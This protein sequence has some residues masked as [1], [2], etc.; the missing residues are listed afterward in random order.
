MM[1]AW[2]SLLLACR[3]CVRACVQITWSETGVRLVLVGQPA[4]REWTSP[5]E[6]GVVLRR[7]SASLLLMSGLCR[8]DVT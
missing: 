3:R 1:Y 8:R 5:K 7:L 2:W 4:L 6:G